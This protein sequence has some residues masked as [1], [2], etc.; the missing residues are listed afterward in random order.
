M[1]SAHKLL[2]AYAALQQKLDDAVEEAYRELKKKMENP[3]KESK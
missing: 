3:E 1:V 2:E